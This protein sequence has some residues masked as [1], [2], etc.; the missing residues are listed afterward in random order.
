MFPVVP[1]R[2][3]SRGPRQSTALRSVAYSSS[4]GV[5]GFV[6][7]GGMTRCVP[8]RDLG[9]GRPCCLKMFL[10]NTC[11]RV[12]K[13]VRGLFNSA[14]TMRMSMGRGKCAVRRV[15]SNRAMTRMLSCMRCGPG[16]LIQA[17]RA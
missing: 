7:A 8:I 6:S 9:D 2:E 5:T 14:G 11:R 15:V 13:S 12:L 16:G 17:L 10:I 1:V 3:L 4:K